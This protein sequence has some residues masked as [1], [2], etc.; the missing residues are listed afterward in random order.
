MA[1]HIK[2]SI[3]NRSYSQLGEDLV[4]KNQLGRI[5]RD[6]SKTYLD[7]GAYHFSIG[8]NTCSLY[9]DGWHGTVV[10]CSSKKLKLFRCFRP[11]DI[12]IAV[13]VV[14]NAYGVVA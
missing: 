7:V 9:K 12:T 3:K 2:Y 8:S 1:R 6:Y 13:A 10:D 4:V 14:P 11:R 5:A